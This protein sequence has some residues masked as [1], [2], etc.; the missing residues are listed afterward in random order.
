[1]NINNNNNNNNNNYYNN[2]NNNSK[3]LTY[4]SLKLFNYWKM[5]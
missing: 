1:M 3:V 5:K 2:N 4:N